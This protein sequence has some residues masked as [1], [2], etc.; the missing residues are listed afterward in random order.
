M[1]SQSLSGASFTV[2]RQSKP[3]DEPTASRSS[4][5]RLS[6]TASERTPVDNNV[7][8]ADDDASFRSLITEAVRAWGYRTIETS[9]L[10]ETL[11]IVE[12]DKPAAVLL[13]ASL[14]DGSGIKALDELKTRS[15][16]TVVII[17]T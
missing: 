2:T 17:V 10:A 12:R 4:K 6:L 3:P 7:L 11:T 16:R 1:I 5:G 15:P 9:T 8:V 14:P 13:D